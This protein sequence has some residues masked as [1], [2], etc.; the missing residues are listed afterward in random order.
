MEASSS[1]QSQRFSVEAF[2]FVGD[3]PF[4]YLHCSVVVCR[5]S[6]PDSR[7]SK[8]CIPGLHVNPPYSVMEKLKE[9]SQ[10]RAK[11][12]VQYKRDPNYL[13]SKGPFSLNEDTV[14]DGPIISL[15]GPQDTQSRLA[16]NKPDK[17]EREGEVFVLEL[18]LY[19]KCYARSGAAIVVSTTVVLFTCEKRNRVTAYIQG[20]GYDNI[21]VF[22]RPFARCMFNFGQQWDE[23]KK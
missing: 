12:E 15:K 18:L 14:N 20:S 8:G 10:N 19:S 17:K 4:V 9:Q 21:S 22:L 2:K 23:M 5:V 3:F 13:I 7:C 1:R 16:E 11:R 6:D